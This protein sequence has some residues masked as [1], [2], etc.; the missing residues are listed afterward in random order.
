MVKKVNSETPH[1]TTGYKTNAETLSKELF[2]LGNKLKEKHLLKRK[3]GQSL[4]KL[5]WNNSLT[6]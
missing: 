2:E 4:N 5:R 3:S 1:R 6:S